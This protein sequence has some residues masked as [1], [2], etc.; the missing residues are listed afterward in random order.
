MSYLGTKWCALG[1][2]LRVHFEPS[3]LL[4]LLKVKRQQHIM[5]NDNGRSATVALDYC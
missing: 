5:N 4:T 3:L 1:R 2:V